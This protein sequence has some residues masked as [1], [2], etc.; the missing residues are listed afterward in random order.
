MGVRTFWQEPPYGAALVDDKSRVTSPWHIW[1]NFV[2][3]YIG[4]RIIVDVTADPPSLVAGAAASAN[5]T[6]PNAEVGDFAVGSFVPMDAAISITA[7]V[8][9][10]NTVTVWLQNLSGGTVDLASGTLRVMVEKKT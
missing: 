6:V 1:L 10:A 7:Q 3:K 5:V 8:S 9:A 2:A 4:K